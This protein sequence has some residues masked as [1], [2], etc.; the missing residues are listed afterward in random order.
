M[1]GKKKR[2]SKD[3]KM[4]IEVIQRAD[5]CF[6]RSKKEVVLDEFTIEQIKKLKELDSEAF[7]KEKHR[8]IVESEVIKEIMEYLR[9]PKKSKGDLRIIIDF[10]GL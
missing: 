5:G 3:L 9:C 2:D 7:Y 6:S 8:K 10:P 4:N 1:Y